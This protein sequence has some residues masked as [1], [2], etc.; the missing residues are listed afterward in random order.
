MNGPVTSEETQGLRTVSEIREQLLDLAKVRHA[1]EAYGTLDF[2]SQIGLE[3]ILRHQ[4]A[5]H[6][7]LRASEML[8][9]GSAVELVLDGDP[10]TQHAV[11]ANF[12]GN[13]L[14]KVQHLVNALAQ[15]MTSVPTARAPL[16][17]NIVAEN[18]LM[19]AAGF[20]P[21]SFGL[22]CSLPTREELGQL[23]EPSSQT[24]LDTI[25]ELLSDKLPSENLA[26]LVSHARVKKHYF[27]LLEMLSKNGANLKIRTRNKPYG[28]K[29]HT[30]QARER[31][32]WL[33]LLQTTEEQILL[34]GILV[35]GNIETARFELKVGDEVIQG[36]ASDAA[37]S[38][39]RQITLGAQ[40][41]AELRVTTLAHEEGVFEPKTSYFLVAVKG[42]NGS[43]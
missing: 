24:V 34:S 42:L 40:V 13:F 22:R 41:E 36:R 28:V 31:V 18:R 38:H 43:L 35:G 2:A 29:L 21:S 20:L 25:T 8:E 15:A 4:D 39:L 14:A 6:E 7:E 10:V 19:V 23:Y 5:L 1:A 12:L 30:K 32:E 16:P 26:G 3:S 27:E 33:D 9:S 17:R 37:K 11:Q